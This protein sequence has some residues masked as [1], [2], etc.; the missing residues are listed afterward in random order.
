VVS[1]PV[2][3]WMVAL[4]QVIHSAP[5]DGSL[6][7]GCATLLGDRVCV[8]QVEVDGRQVSQVAILVDML[9]EATRPSGSSGT[10]PD[11]VTVISTMRAAGTEQQAIAS[12]VV[13]ELLYQ[14]GLRTA[15]RVPQTAQAMAQQELNDYLTDPAAGQAAGI[16]PPGVT[17]QQ[18]FM[19]PTMIEGF[20]HGVVISDERST[21]AA[22]HTDV[23]V[24][25]RQQIAEHVILINGGA[26][27]FSLAASLKLP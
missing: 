18:Y 8:P 14:A 26:P 6:P 1:N 5:S 21:L 12:A 16:V 3:P 15:T 25:V 22:S 20:E 4:G 27:G 11:K 19:S 9:G 7:G 17:P 2:D 24:W 23:A 10:L 13:D